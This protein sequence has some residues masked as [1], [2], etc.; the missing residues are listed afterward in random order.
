MT[1]SK[2]HWTLSKQIPVA[3]I[4]TIALQTIGAVW[5]AATISSNVSQN[6][7]AIVALQARPLAATDASQRIT[8]LET[9]Y[10]FILNHLSSIDDKIDRIVPPGN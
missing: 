6:E 10:T 5:W 1:S 4:L 9:Q 7:R 3:L 2:E 8:R